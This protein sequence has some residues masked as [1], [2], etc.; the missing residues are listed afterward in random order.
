MW[1]L[2]VKTDLFIQDVKSC[3]RNRL[4]NQQGAGTVE[5]V[6]L[7][8]VVVIGMVAGAS[9]M[10]PGLKEFFMGVVDKIKETAGL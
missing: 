8:A 2:I 4:S 3:L 10:F 9:A 7:I 6:L 1:N 5:Y